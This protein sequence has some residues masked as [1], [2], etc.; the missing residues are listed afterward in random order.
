MTSLSSA[1]LWPSSR[2]GATLTIS[3][4]AVQENYRLL[5]AMTGNATCAAVV[6]ADAYG[7]GAE[8]IAP[9]LEKAGATEFFV[10]HVDEGIALRDI[11]R[12]EHRITV[13]H[14]PR[15]AAA[16][17]CVTFNLR[18][19][20]NTPDQ[21]MTW[22]KEAS[23]QGRP[24]DAAIQVD[25]GMSRFGLS[26]TEFHSLCGDPSSLDGITVSLLMSHLACADTAENE[27]NALQKQRMTAFSAMMPGVPVSLSASSGIFLGTDYHFALVRPG[28]ALYGLSPG[29]AV[30]ENP[31]RPVVRLS[32]HVLQ[33]RTLSPGDGL[34]YG[35]TYRATKPTRI[36]IIAAGYADGVSRH[37]SGKG[38]AWAGDIPLPVLGRVSM[39]SLAV[40]LSALP[41]SRQHPDMQVDLIG[42]HY[43][44]DD[45][46]RAAGTIG[47]EILTALGHR[48]HRHYLSSE[49]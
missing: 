21:I 45:A 49:E 15:P 10:A 24:L 13:L 3:P 41:E 47:Y 30:K 1:S 33:F 35:L 14:G 6:K 8:K 48:Y 9:A 2:A 4:D 7:L 18:P 25:T 42:P 28:A 22:K 11:I 40:D 43:S 29:T 23:R 5:N 12:P 27:A 39:D 16:R 19:V 37:A 17:D 36:A 32:A 20:L 38:C 44:V 34:G 26:A 46:G 31:L